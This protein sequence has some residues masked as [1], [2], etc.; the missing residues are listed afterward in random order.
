M[1]LHPAPFYHD[2]ADGPKS[3]AAHWVETS[4]GVR[5]R[6]GHWRAEEEKGTILL[7]PGRTEYIEKYG[8]TA[9][10]FA[11]R[12]YA[13]L[14]V[15]WRGQG[16]ADRLIPDRLSGYVGSFDDYQQDV[17]ATLFAADA[18]D[19]PKPYYLIGHSMGGAIGLRGAMSGLP[20][21]AAV[22][23]A[24]MWGILMAA[25]MKPTAWALSWASK[26]AG[27]G[28]K[29][30]PGTT[31]ETYVLAE[32][33]EGNTL[34]HDPDMYVYMQE[35]MRRY[36]DMAL[37]GPSMHWL[38]EAMRDMKE[39]AAQPAPD[40]PCLTFLG[41]QERIVDPKAIVTRMES[42]PRGELVMIPGAEHEVLM[43]LP[44]MREPIHDQIAA[45]FDA[46]R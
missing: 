35:Q 5:I 10:S 25:L 43:E 21:K 42:W 17:A 14:A 24:P 15:D 7:F 1:E 41:E 39:L 27:M 26:K 18:L 45:F 29:I 11:D 32:P 23:S 28:H 46:H 33:F 37:A 22:F 2:V 6:I 38:H 31:V 12:G 40:L 36:P 16:L 44:E 30:A 3:G 34:T 20:V 4:D 13:M 19:V 9:Q 8:R